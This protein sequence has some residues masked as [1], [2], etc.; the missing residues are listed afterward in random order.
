MAAT[1]ARSP[2][3]GLLSLGL[4]SLGLLSLGED[5]RQRVAADAD[6][7]RHGA[8]RRRDGHAGLRDRRVGFWVLS[9]SGLVILGAMVVSTLK[10][11][12]VRRL[13][14]RLRRQLRAWD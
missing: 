4:P 10:G 2:S 13:V 14:E 9:L 12:E 1:A 8:A 6:A 3:L 7:E 11:E 5:L